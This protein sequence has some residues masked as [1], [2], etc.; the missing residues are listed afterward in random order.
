MDL[1][2][3]ADQPADMIRVG[4]AH[5]CP[6]QLFYTKIIQYR[7]YNPGDIVFPP[8]PVS[9]VNKHR[10]SVRKTDQ[11]RVPLPYIHKYDIGS[12]Y[13]KNIFPDQYIG[14]YNAQQNSP[15]SE[16]LLEQE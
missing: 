12:G 1:L 3:H 14:N 11:C 5:H 9:C 10:F 8:V 15:G 16:G 4:M 7:Q 13:R 6:I 2:H